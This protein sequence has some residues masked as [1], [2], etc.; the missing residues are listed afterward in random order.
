[1]QSNNNKHEQPQFKNLQNKQKNVEY[2]FFNRFFKNLEEKSLIKC[3][4]R[5]PEWQLQKI[6][7]F[8]VIVKKDLSQ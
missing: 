5:S 8:K 3:A 1:M 6:A 2:S 7:K 4:N